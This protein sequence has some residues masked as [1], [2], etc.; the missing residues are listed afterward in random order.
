M[1]VLF[2]TLSFD[3]ITAV[4][5]FALG[6]LCLVFSNNAIRMII[7]LEIMARAATLSFITY[8]AAR[9]NTAITQALV[10]TVIVVEVVVTS[11]ALT[12]IMNISRVTKSVDVRHHN[13]LKG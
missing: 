9:G 12:L 4:I 2:S 8:G 13:K 11:I 5:L 1:D 3:I 7:G 10:I 6:F